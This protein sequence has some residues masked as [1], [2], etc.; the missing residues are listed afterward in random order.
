MA[1]AAW[2]ISFTEN[3]HRPIIEY[4]HTFSYSLYFLLAKFVK[5]T[6]KNSSL[7]SWHKV[8]GHV[9]CSKTSRLGT[10]TENGSY[11]ASRK[12]NLKILILFC[13]DKNYCR[14]LSLV[15]DGMDPV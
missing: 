5:K 13:R 11:A 14:Y 1:L 6:K 9:R 15:S 10:T 8:T 2:S 3:L 7:K 12:T 4:F